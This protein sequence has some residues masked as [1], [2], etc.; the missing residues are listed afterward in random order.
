MLMK[1]VYESLNENG[2]F[3]VVES[4][5]DDE[6]KNLGGLISKFKINIVS[7]N[8]LIET[9]GG[10]NFSFKDYEVWAKEIGFKN[11]KKLDLNQGLSI[12]ISNK[13]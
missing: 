11:S 12:I 5:I 10:F 7:L 8:M 9:F 1:K 13:N 4:L 2:S 3:I 6:R